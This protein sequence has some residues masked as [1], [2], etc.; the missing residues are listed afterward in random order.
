MDIS[1]QSLYENRVNELLPIILQKV[2]ENSPKLLILGLYFAEP[3][4]Y[5]LAQIG[6]SSLRGDDITNL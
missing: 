1:S 2:T 5:I 4:L 3:V 6:D